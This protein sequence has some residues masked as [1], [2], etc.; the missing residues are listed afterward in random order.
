MNGLTFKT[1]ILSSLLLSISGFPSISLAMKEPYRPQTSPN[2]SKLGCM[3][4]HRN[5][6]N[7]PIQTIKKHNKME[8]KNKKPAIK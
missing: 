8:R 3:M 6:S 1:T 7:S 2:T 5:E 4:C